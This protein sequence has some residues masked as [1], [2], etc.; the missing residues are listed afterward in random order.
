LVGRR[1][2][3]RRVK[4]LLLVV[5]FHMQGGARRVELRRQGSP[6][7]T[8]KRNKKYG[9]EQG[10]KKETDYTRENRKTHLRWVRLHDNLGLS[11]WEEEKRPGL[12]IKVRHHT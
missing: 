11:L 10:G 3:I 6:R 2:A 7:Q 4:K 12:K 8:E 9:K 5:I 1:P